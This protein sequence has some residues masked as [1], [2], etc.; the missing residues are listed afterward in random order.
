MFDFD[1]LYPSKGYRFDATLEDLLILKHPDFNS[2]DNTAPEIC[3]MKCNYAIGYDFDSVDP[4]LSAFYCASCDVV[5]IQESEL[6]SAN[7]KQVARK[8]F[9][10]IPLEDELFVLKEFDAGAIRHTA[11]VAMD[12]ED[13]KRYYYKVLEDYRRKFK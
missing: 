7:Y 8:F 5:L 1:D 11:C 6:K 2:Y 13:E 10:S 3:C 4:P 12:E 9:W